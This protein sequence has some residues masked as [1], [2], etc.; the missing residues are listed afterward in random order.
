VGRGRDFALDRREFCFLAKFCNNISKEKMERTYRKII[1]AGDLFSFHLEVR[2]TDLWISASERL[3]S[4]ARDLVFQGR[5]QIES[6]ITSNPGFKNTLKPWEKDPFAPFLVKEMIRA[7]KV[8]GVGPMASVAGALAQFVGEGLLELVDQVIVEN[9]GDVFLK[10]DRPATVSVLAGDSPL[11]GKIGLVFSEKRMP[12]GV[13]SSSGTVGHS[14]SFGRADAVCIISPSAV[15]GDAAAT[16]LGNLIN[17][18]NDLKKAASWA[19]RI[20]GVDGGVVILG[21]EIAAWG[22]V[23]LVAL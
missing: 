21:D 11:S 13:C 4:E 19:E 2:E 7:S 8:A 23:E 15:L 18:K 16:A 10:T 9:G 12:V 20:E 14:L 6:Y 5:R 1:E 22:D 17:S 3:E